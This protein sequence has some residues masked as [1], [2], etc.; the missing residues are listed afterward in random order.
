MAQAF[1]QWN[2]EAYEKQ[3]NLWLRWN[4]DAPF[5]AQQGQIHVYST[6]YF[7]SEPTD[8]TERWSWDNENNYDWDTGLRWGTDWHCAYIAQRSP[9]GPYAYLI[10]LITTNCMGPNVSRKVEAVATK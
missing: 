10:Q 8:K 9:N 1:F 2:L 5:R 4:T 7:P 6:D 3:G